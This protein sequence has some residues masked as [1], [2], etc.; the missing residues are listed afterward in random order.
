MAVSPSGISI[1]AKITTEHVFGGH[2]VFVYNMAG[3]SERG[4][5][6]LNMSIKWLKCLKQVIIQPTRIT[7]ESKTLIDIVA[8]THEQYLM[9]HIVYP[10]SISDHDLVGTIRKKNCRRFHPRKIH[11]R[12]F[13]RY[14][15]GNFKSDLRNCSWE[16]I[17]NGFS[18]INDAWNS[19]KYHLTVIID[20][21]AP[22]TE[23]MV[24][25]R[26]CPWLTTE[27]KSKIKERDFF[28]RKA[29]KSE[30]TTD[31]LIRNTVTQDIRQRKANY[32]RSLF[33]ENINSPTQFWNQI[34]KCYLT[35]EKKLVTSEV[36][37]IDETTTLDKTSISI[38]NG[39]CKYFTNVGKTLQMTLTTL[40]K[41]SVGKS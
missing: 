24:R 27:I 33:S 30:M 11:T 21:H 19:F 35:K 12:N 4:L 22:M 23:K 6:C 41:H 28:L 2:Y 9:K 39:F 13:S 38:P 10:N 3:A 36:F 34:K 8:T 16:N 17:F 31:W 1:L 40:G 37:D 15:Q 26:D 32:N 7:P 20:K 5:Q 25:G 29:R 18:D 14:S